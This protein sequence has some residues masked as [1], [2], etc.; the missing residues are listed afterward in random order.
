MYPIV[1]EPFC[2]A[3]LRRI[4]MST[5]R[6]KFLR[7]NELGEWVEHIKLCVTEIS[8]GIGRFSLIIREG[9]NSSLVADFPRAS[10]RNVE[11][12]SSIVLRIYS[13][14]GTRVALRFEEPASLKAIFKILA[15]NEIPCADKLAPSNTD[16]CNITNIMP[17]LSDPIIQE[18]ILKLLFREDFKRFVADLGDLLSGYCEDIL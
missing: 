6:C 15:E 12:L 13:L 9:D 5:Y 18:F 17:D 14:S 16:S 11:S 3:E 1:D 8:T 2:P 7:C 10:I 4:S